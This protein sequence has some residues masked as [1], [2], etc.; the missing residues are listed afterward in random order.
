MCGVTTLVG[1]AGLVHRARA[2]AGGTL[3]A[4]RG[5]LEWNLPL[6]ANIAGLKH[7]NVASNELTLER[8]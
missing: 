6:A 2:S 4:T 1:L 7:F 3:A 5:V 8:E